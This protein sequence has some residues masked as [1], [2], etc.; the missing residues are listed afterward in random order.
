MKID[1][2]LLRIMGIVAGIIIIFIII[3]ALIS[4][5]NR[6]KKFTLE[7]ME[8]KL[9]TLS[10][11][12]YE[13]NK[14]SLPKDGE[15][16]S[17]TTG[18]F[19]SNGNFKSLTLTSGKTCTGEIVVSNNNGYY[20]YT[21][22][23]SCGSDI[24]AITLSEKLTEPTNV[25]TTGEG[26]YSYGS[27]Y[28]YRGENINNYLMLNDK[29]WRIVKVD[30]DKSVRV[31]EVKKSDS[32]Y[33]DNRYNLDKK[34]NTGINDF[35]ANNINSRIKNKLEDLYNNELKFNEET[36]AY[37]V[38][39]DLCIGKRSE[40]ENVND[41][42]IECSETIKDQVFG[43]IQANEYFLASLDQNCVGMTS[44]SCTNY[45]YLARLDSA[46]WTL[47]ADEDTSYKAY[48]LDYGISIANTSNISGVAIV[49]HLSKNT[50][51]KSG[52]GTLDDPYTVK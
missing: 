40:N 41:G 7:E 22:K 51:Y 29:L 16:A 26:L 33:W 25:L 44:I 23:L 47:T 30:S 50:L 10:K 39:H 24:K 18:Y 28:I 42:S 15:E 32:S 8:S 49:A 27:S 46:T 9:I 20:L 1:Q 37:F 12:Y 5:C 21:P 31:I 11:R 3:I 17:L 45:N 4:S 2:K 52:T 6:N 19:I 48:R 13:K 36:K 43:L 14:S 35:V 34:S 38:K